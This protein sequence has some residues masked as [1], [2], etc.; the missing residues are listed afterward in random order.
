MRGEWVRGKTPFPIIKH[1]V[2]TNDGYT[3]GFGNPFALIFI[4]HESMS[5][6]GAPLLRG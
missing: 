6:G 3:L 2:R 5:K 4:S 1:E